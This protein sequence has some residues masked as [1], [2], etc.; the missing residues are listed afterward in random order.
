[1]AARSPARALEALARHLTP[2]PTSAPQQAAVAGGSLS[3]GQ[4]AQFHRHGWVNIEGCLSDAD[5]AGME[6]AYDALIDAQAQDWLR[7]GKVRSA[8]EGLGFATRLAA[9]AEE[10]SDDD[11]DTEMRQFVGELD[12]ARL[13]IPEAI[14]FFFC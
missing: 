4:L 14:E 5:F 13:D 8:H 3:A 11:Y 10:M 2:H 6:R 12:E 7:A 9:L 1:M